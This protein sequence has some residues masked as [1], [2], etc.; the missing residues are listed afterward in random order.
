[1]KAFS[2]IMKLERG[3]RTIVS[4]CSGDVRRLLALINKVGPYD[5]FFIFF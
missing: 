4:A 1:M 3:F 2:S 5:I